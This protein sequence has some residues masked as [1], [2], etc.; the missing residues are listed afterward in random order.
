MAELLE[1]LEGDAELFS[2]YL[3]PALV[4]SMALLACSGTGSRPQ[5]PGTRTGE[6]S[7]EAVLRS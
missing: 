7:A 2:F 4:D 1:G 6:G 5:G 3:S